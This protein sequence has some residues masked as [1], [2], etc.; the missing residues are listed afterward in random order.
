MGVIDANRI[1]EAENVSDEFFLL[2]KNYIYLDEAC[3][4]VGKAVGR[5]FRPLPPAAESLPLGRVADVLC[6]RLDDDKLSQTKRKFSETSVITRTLRGMTPISRKKKTEAQ[7]PYE[8]DGTN[9]L[10]LIGKAKES[11]LLLD[12]VVASEQASVSSKV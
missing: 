7:G 6:R 12:S 1:K 2:N 3:A 11:S 8:D 9:R 10:R 4:P 5:I